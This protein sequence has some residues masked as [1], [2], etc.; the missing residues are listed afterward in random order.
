[1]SVNFQGNPK[2]VIVQPALVI[3]RTAIAGPPLPSWTSG[4]LIRLHLSR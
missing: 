3:D 1:M 4:G 2:Y